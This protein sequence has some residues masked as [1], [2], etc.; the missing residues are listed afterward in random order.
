MYILGLDIG[1][2]KCAAVTAEVFGD[3]IEILKRAEIKT[4][5]KISADA[6]LDV[7]A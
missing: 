7:I 3:K 6:L 5:T 1:G 2:T 4:D